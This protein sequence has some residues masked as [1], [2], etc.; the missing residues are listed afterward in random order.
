MNLVLD[1]V[2]GYYNCTSD[3]RTIPR[4]SLGL[5]FCIHTAEIKASE[6]HDLYF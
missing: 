3:N 2:V 4:D 6:S 1:S 5:I